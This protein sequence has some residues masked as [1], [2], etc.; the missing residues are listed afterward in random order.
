MP[1]DWWAEAEQNM[2]NHVSMG[3]S[4]E[5]ME[6]AF[7]GPA[8]TNGGQDVSDDDVSLGSSSFDPYECSENDEDYEDL[9]KPLVNNTQ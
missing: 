3:G 1:N 4:M 7:F 5:D 6:E 2:A 8:D 9:Q